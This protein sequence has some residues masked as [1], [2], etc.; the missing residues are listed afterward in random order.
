MTISSRK[1]LIC[2]KIERNIL[3]VFMRNTS[4]SKLMDVNVYL[5]VFMRVISEREI[6]M[7]K[8]MEII[9]K[10]GGGVILFLNEK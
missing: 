5:Y 2:S 1:Y 7:K 8:D 6:L 3:L 9:K 10:G 4:N